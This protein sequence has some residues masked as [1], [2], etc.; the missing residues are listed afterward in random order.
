MCRSWTA[1]TTWLVIETWFSHLEAK[2]PRHIKRHILGSWD[3]ILLSYFLTGVLGFWNS[4]LFHLFQ[5]DAVFL[6][7]EFNR[8]GIS[9][10]HLSALVLTESVKSVF[11]CVNFF[12]V[13]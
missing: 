5:R 1:S 10:E 6:L 4:A 11:D 9:L 3:L 8:I 12:D 2:Q 7:A 13:S